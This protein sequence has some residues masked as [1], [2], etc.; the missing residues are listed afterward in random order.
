[1]PPTLVSPSD[2]LAALER[3][4]IPNLRNACRIQKLLATRPDGFTVTEISRELRIPYTTT[5]RIMA[6]LQLEGFA[7]KVGGKFELGPVVI[8]IG[9][10]SLAGTEIRDFAL[11]VLEALTARTEETSHLAIPCEGRPLIVAVQDSPHPLRAASRPGFLA[12][13]HCS[14][15]GKALLAFHYHD[16]VDEIL[17]RGPLHRR[18]SHTMIKPADVKRDLELTRKRG[19]SLDDEEYHP[20]VRCLAAPVRSAEGAVVAAIG[21]TAASIRFTKDRIPE[22]SAKVLSAARELSE[23]IGHMI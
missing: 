20:G 16:R 23:K 6:T 17:G 19:F 9:N 5:L 22:I 14:S 8:H 3:Y 15:T 11:P 2:E 10:A 13:P 12:E 1:M 21:I 4:Q 18:T 7:R